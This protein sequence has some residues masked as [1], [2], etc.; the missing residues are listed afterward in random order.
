MF[1][2]RNTKIR[3]H[4]ASN[5]LVVALAKHVP[6]DRG[7][8]ICYLSRQHL[9]TRIRIF[10]DFMTEQIRALDL[11]CMTRFNPEARALAPVASAGLAA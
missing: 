2:I 4:L 1:L 3:D 8:Y 5:E 9:P 6:D 10:V 7:H 11:N